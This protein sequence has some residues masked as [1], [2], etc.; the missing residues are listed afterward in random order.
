MVNYHRHSSYSNIWGFKD[1]AASNEAYAKRA[2]ELGQSALSCVEHGYQGNPWECYELAQKYNLKLIFGA[3]AYW[4]RDRHEQD[5]SNCH[6]IL[7]A[8]NENGR[9]AINDV[10]S[11]ANLS[12]YYYR[13]RLDL[14]LLLS[15]P[16]NDV[17]ITTAC[18]A[19]WQYDD[20]EDI[21]VRLHNH[22]GSNFFLEI[23]YH[24]TEKQRSLNERIKLLS[25]K[26]KIELIVGL[27]S[28]Y[29][30][31]TEKQERDYMLEDSKVSFN[32][33]ESGWFMDY[34]DEETVINRFLE[35]GVFEP[36][37]IK[38]AIDY[39]NICMEFED[40]TVDNPVFSKQIKLPT[41]FDGKHVVEGKLLPKLSQEEK[42]KLY[43][44]TIT[45]KFQDYMK[46]VDPK[47]YKR[48]FDGVKAE[49]QTVKDTRLADY[50]FIDYFII[51]RMKKLGGQMTMTGRGSAVSYFSNTLLGFS[52]VDRFQS[53]VKI[54]PERFIST[55]RIIESN[56]LADIDMNVANQAIAEQAQAEIMGENHAYPMI[57]YGTAKKKAAFKMYARSQNMDFALANKISAQIGDYDEAVKNADEDE[58][59]DINIFDFV[60]PEH[61]PYIEASMKYWGIITDKKKAPCSYLLYNGDI[62]REIGLIKCKSDSTKKEYITTVCEGAVA[63]SYKF[64]KN[65]LLSVTVVDITDKV[66]KRIGISPPSIEEL[67][68]ITAGDKKT[69][70]IYR[71]GLTMGINQ[72]ER[73]SSRKKAMAYK[74]SNIS[75]LSAFVA[76]VRPGFKSM[77]KQF[78]Q[79]TA[80]EYGVPAIDRILQT[81]EL[82]YSYILYQ[83]QMMAVLNYAGFGMDQCYGIIKSIAKKH[84]E[85]VL[86]LKEQF[87]KGLSSK[88]TNNDGVSNESAQKM[89]EMIWQ[90]ISDAT[91]YSFN[92][93]HSYCMALDSLYQAYQKAHYP[94]EFYE[95][96][97]QTFSDKGKKDKVAEL[98]KEMLR[99]FGIK[100][101]AYEFGADNRRFHADPEHNQII[102]SL[103]SIKGLN[104]SCAKDLYELSQRKTYRSFYELWKDMKS[105][106]SLDSGKIDTLAKIGFFSRFA[107]V[108]KILRFIEIAEITYKRTQFSQDNV[109]DD[110]RY[111]VERFSGAKTS[112]LYRQFDYD[113][114]LEQIWKDLPDTP[115]TMRD[116]L[117][118]EKELLGYIRSI[119]PEINIGYYV[120]LDINKKYKNPV[121]TLYRLQDGLEET[122]K[123]KAGT[124]NLDP[125]D[126]GDIIRVNA[127]KEE[128]K[129]RMV[130][131]KWEQNSQDKETILVA[132]QMKNNENNY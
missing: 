40:F 127:T 16:A 11:E 50:F 25:Q 27:D 22:F 84:P 36:S 80:F 61:R 21:I 10:L 78:E 128:G 88:L 75:E 24:L 122:M 19:F 110:L 62:R 34:P 109:P 130:D 106:R 93:S 108:T 18:V 53:P 129:W 117:K 8:K 26:Y 107:D 31:E 39:T 33:D 56:S 47:E 90:V 71:N 119:Y 6:I 101:G 5:K 64:L 63:E 70:D 113:K 46:T 49:V 4:V 28:H 99:G 77:W 37:V 95:V 96:L 86:P 111:V 12:G 85:K 76:A 124:Y 54:Y 94:Y 104:A 100:E 52:N 83:E 103:L 66:F 59:D 15:L 72:V 38:R 92:A 23:Q 55:T 17:V 79:R 65:D 30:Y 67:K 41:L 98:K 115:T 9:Q 97:L 14:E 118:Y 58:K 89:S 57:S 123:I 120:V 51:K 73:A 121:A 29:I 44:R 81:E 114:A 60:A 132:Y 1:S 116:K 3:E 2:V 45:R 105:L 102:P 82:P 112:K 43:S 126:I 13:P 42:D 7:L 35:Q 87:L 131:G 20:I 68:R 48:Y 91:N 125:I 74:P 69:W 32:D